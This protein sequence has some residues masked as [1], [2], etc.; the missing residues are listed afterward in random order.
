MTTVANPLLTASET[1]RYFKV[2]RGM[3]TSDIS[4]KKRGL[5]GRKSGTVRGIISV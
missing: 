1:A 2:Q 4:N 3:Q 5:V